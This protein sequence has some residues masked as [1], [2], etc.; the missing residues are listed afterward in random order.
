MPIDVEEI[1]N[2]VSLQT[3]LLTGHS[4]TDVAVPSSNFIEPLIAAGALQKLDK[5][6]L[7]NWR[8]LDPRWLERLGRIDPGNQYGVPYLWGIHAFGYEV[9]RVTKALGREPEASWK[10]LFDPDNA[11]RLA[12]CG[13]AWQDSAGS[14]MTKLAL[15]AIGR[16]PGSEDAA[17]LLAA[18]QAFMR[19]RPYV[20]YLDSTVRTRTDLATGDLCIAVSASGDVLTARDIAREARTGADLRFV[21]PEE[22]AL[23]WVD[24]LVIPANAPHPEAAHRFIDFMLE[25]AVIAKVTDASKYANANGDATALVAAAVREDP[26]IYPP[27]STMTRLHLLAADSAAYAR[28]RTRMWTR[29]RTTPSSDRTPSGS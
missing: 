16:D 28:A 1:V 3:K 19:V 10:L 22:G 17:D 14:I 18:E 20:R 9:G 7:P 29:V 13:I 21:V 11:R 26:D 15:L 25:P 5:S 27:Q 12:G 8:H 23:L 4:G 24:L 6:K 2:N